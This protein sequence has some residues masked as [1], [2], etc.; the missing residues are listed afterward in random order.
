[1]DNKK[2]LMT[3]GIVGV[4]GVALAYLGH[5]YLTKKEEPETEMDKAAETVEKASFFNFLFSSD[6]KDKSEETDKNSVNEN[7]K[8]S[9]DG[10]ASNP[11]VEGEAIKAVVG[12]TIGTFSGFF[13]QNEKVTETTE[14]AE[15]K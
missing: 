9:V 4:G 13:R 2:N 5:S 10:V 7:M 15:E 6:K 12:N 1:M 3:A 14:N 11:V 8:I